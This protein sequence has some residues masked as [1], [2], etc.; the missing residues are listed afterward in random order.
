MMYP[1]KT[2]GPEHARP[3]PHDQLNHVNLAGHVPGRGSM[4]A[5]ITYVKALEGLDKTKNGEE[6]QLIV[7]RLQELKP[8][9]R[10][11]GLFDVMDIRSPEVAAIMGV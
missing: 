5:F 7:N 2:A 3:V 11:V 4:A 10:A 8:P 6:Y 9:L 1:P